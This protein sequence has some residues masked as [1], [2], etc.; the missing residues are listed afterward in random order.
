MPD[1][2]DKLNRETLKA[3]RGRRG[4]TQQQLADAIKCTK[5]TVSRWERGISSRVR[6]QDHFIFGFEGSTRPGAGVTAADSPSVHRFWR[7]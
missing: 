6:G 5:D 2:T 3:I 7:P 1:I 4:L